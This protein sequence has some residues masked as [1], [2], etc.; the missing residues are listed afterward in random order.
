[1]A[2]QPSLVAD[3]LPN[4]MAPLPVLVSTVAAPKVAASP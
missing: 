1:M 4:V 3:F 2:T